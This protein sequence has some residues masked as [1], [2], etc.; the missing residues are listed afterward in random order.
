MDTYVVDSECSQ[1]IGPELREQ[2]LAP[3]ISGATFTL[4]EWAHTEIVVQAVYRKSRHTPFGDVAAILPLTS[5]REEALV[6]SFSKH[7]ASIL[8]ARILGREGETLETEIIHDC[9]GEIANVIAGQTKALLAGTP[10]H[11][12][13]A[14]PTVV[15]GDGLKARKGPWGDCMIIVFGSNVGELALQVFMKS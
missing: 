11:F 12:S 2:M 7:T 14:T 15:M 10:H 5:A 3:F 4:R 9:V 13:L 1:P 8:A 6:L